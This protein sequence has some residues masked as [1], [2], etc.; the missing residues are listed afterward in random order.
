MKLGLILCVVAVLLFWPFASLSTQAPA[1]G[2][3]PN[4]LFI[5]VDDL[6]TRLGCYGDPIVKT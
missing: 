3:K 1:A 5:V 6:N 2:R 4:V